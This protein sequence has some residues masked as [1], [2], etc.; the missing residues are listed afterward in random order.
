MCVMRTNRLTPVLIVVTFPVCVRLTQVLL[1]QEGMAA[2]KQV[3]TDAVRIWLAWVA[4][5]RPV[6]K[7]YAS[8]CSNPKDLAETSWAWRR[9]HSQDP[10]GERLRRALGEKVCQELHSSMAGEW[11]VRGL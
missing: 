5:T 9:S 8:W 3:I 4:A 11:D 2:S 1:I 10:H 7:P 6:E